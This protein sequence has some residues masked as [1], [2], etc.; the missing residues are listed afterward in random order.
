MRRYNTSLVANE[1][2]DICNIMSVLGLSK[3]DIM[4]KKFGFDV[5]VQWKNRP[6]EEPEVWVGCRLCHGLPKECECHK[7]IP[8]RPLRQGLNYLWERF[9]TS[10]D[11]TVSLGLKPMLGKAGLGIR[12][13]MQRHPDTD[14]A[15]REVHRAL[16]ERF[17]QARIDECMER[18][19][20]YP[21][22]SEKEASLW[23]FEMSEVEKP[24][25]AP[26]MP[27][28]LR[29]P[30]RVSKDLSIKSICRLYLH[31]WNIHTPD[32]WIRLCLLEH[33]E[34]TN[35]TAFR[36]NGV[37]FVADKMLRAINEDFV[38]QKMGISVTNADTLVRYIRDLTLQSQTLHEQTL[39]ERTRV[40]YDAVRDR[41]RTKALSSGGKSSAYLNLM[42]RKQTLISFDDDEE[43]EDEDLI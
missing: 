8:T 25:G 16:S 43:S 37:K 42:E 38:C 19:L 14:G 5:K 20:P 34:E 27:L 41:F 32:D 10:K 15:A 28:S 36:R 13:L 3:L 33:G 26:V 9:G 1:I 21:F 12:I 22:F 35:N 2:M 40:H 29:T 4:A 30:P 23:D 39:L 6:L 11:P 7:S 31:D 17:L 18:P 24:T